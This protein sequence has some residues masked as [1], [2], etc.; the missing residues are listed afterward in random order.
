MYIMKKKIL[1]TFIAVMLVL[2][3]VILPVVSLD[4]Y[5][6]GE[7]QVTDMAWEVLDIVN[8]ERAA[9]GL[10]S[11]TMDKGFMEAAQVRAVELTILFSHTRPDGSSCFTA[12]PSENQTARG[13]NI[14]AGQRSAESV[15]NAWMNSEGHRANI[16]NGSYNTI[17]IACVYAPDS[18]YGY[19]WVQCFGSTVNEGITKGN[20]PTSPV[21]TDDGTIPMY[22]V[23][24]PNSSEHFYTSNYYELVN[25]GNAGWQYEGVGWYA[26]GDGTDV[27]RMY[28][29]N[30]GDHH[31]T[32]NPEERDMLINAGWQYEGVCWYSSGDVPLYRAY[33]PNAW[34]GAHHYT[35]NWSEMLSLFNAGWSDEG[36]AWYGVR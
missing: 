31:Y 11:L 23:Y 13:E 24:N 34:A 7:V 25:I 35:T 10:Q 20:V 18:Y 3:I 32:M 14:A 6:A 17:G 15:M 9:N 12:M 19:Y 1:A 21:T 8:Q 2:S 33:N 30:V 5:A 29:P 27:Y 36:I 28:N 26:Y 16:L 4:T 22:R